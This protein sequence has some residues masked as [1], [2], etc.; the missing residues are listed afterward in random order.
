MDCLHPFIRDLLRGK[1]KGVVLVEYC[2]VAHFFDDGSMKPPCLRC[3]DCGEW[4]SY[5]EQIKIG[6]ESVDG[7]RGTS[8]KGG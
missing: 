3:P 1:L 6:Q 8:Y 7:E 2:C 4:I 5:E